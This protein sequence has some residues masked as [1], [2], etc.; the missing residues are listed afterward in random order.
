V[1]GLP[2]IYPAGAVLSVGFFEESAQG[3]GTEVAAR[4][5]SPQDQIQ[6]TTRWIWQP[7]RVLLT[8]SNLTFVGLASYD[9]TYAPAPDILPIPVRPGA[10]PV[11]S[12]SGPRCSGDIQVTVL[13]AETVSAAGRV[14][15]AWRIH[16]L[17]HYVAQSSVDVTSD[18]TSL[19]SPE[20]GTAVTSDATTSGK[21][22]G[23]AFGAHQVTALTSHP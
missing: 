14:W 2:Q 19:F 17:L 23:Q 16:T 7:S 4:A 6:S 9:C 10:L 20:L 8:F 22:A 5:V 12:W 1:L 3:A 21:V 18:T 15:D 13:G 11:Q